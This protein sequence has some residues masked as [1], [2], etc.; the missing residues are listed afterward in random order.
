MNAQCS[1]GN[2]IFFM[3]NMFFYLWDYS[4][5]DLSLKH[6][7]TS[8]HLLHILFLEPATQGL[9]IDTLSSTC[10]AIAGLT[11]LDRPVTVSFGSSNVHWMVIYVLDSYLTS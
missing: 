3:K 6:V 4:V 7:C 2:G 10:V 9:M 5:R 1:V 8:V 11:I